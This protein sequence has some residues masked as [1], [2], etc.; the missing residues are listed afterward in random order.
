MTRIEVRAIFELMGRPPEHLK[1][2]LNTL[3]LKIGS[4]PGVKILDKKYHDPLPVK[5]TDNLF[6]TFA[7]L[8]L[9]LDSINTLLMII[10]I[11][12]PSN[13]ELVSPENLKLTND[14]LNSFIN[15]LLGKMHEHGAILKRTLMERNILINQLEH[16]KNEIGEDRLK[17]ILISNRKSPK[18]QPAKM[19]NKTPSKKKETKTKK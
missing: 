9:E 17:K 3:V 15:A 13:L 6:T 1:E 18:K 16:I 10:Y 8:D 11:Y 14:D 7:E 2:S 5:K 12:S 4:E 19:K